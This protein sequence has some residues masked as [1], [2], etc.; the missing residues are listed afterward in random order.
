MNWLK[1]LI[2]SMINPQFSF[3]E[4]G[5]GG[6]IGTPTG[7]PEAAAVPSSTPEQSPEAG[8]GNGQPAANPTPQEIADWQKDERFERMWKKDPNGLYKSYTELEKVYNPL[9]EKHTALETQ[10]NEVSALFKEMGIEPTKEQIKAVLDELKGFKDPNN[11]VNK[12]NDFLGHWLDDESRYRKYG[13]K[14]DT[15]FNDL[16]M[17]EWREK[18]PGM[19]TEQIQHQIDLE[20]KVEKF[21]NFQATEQSKQTMGENLSKIQTLCNRYG[22]AFSTD[23]KTQ[24]LNDCMKKGVSTREVYHTFIDQFGE[25]L[26]KSLRD[27]VQKEQLQNL[28]KNKQGVIPAAGGTKP[29]DNNAKMSFR[30]KALKAF[31]G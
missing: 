24:F 15:F 23:I 10:V 2:D 14:I 22:F 17:E 9:K 26:E 5:A 28:E 19:T 3:A 31:G 6:P 30:D 18:F 25:Q 8:A 13:T 7:T 1:R 20:K 21:E 11:I 12:R 4:D 29:P 16:Q 27:K